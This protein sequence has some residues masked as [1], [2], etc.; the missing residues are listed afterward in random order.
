[1]ENNQQNLN[2]SKYE[3]SKQALLLALSKYEKK[4]KLKFAAKHLLRSIFTFFIIFLLFLLAERTPFQSELLRFAVNVVFYAAVILAVYGLVKIFK[5]QTHATELSSEIEKSSGRFNSALLSA[6]DFALNESSGKNSLEAV[7]KKLTVCSAAPLLTEEDSE[8]AL[9]KISIKKVSK[10]LTAILIP[11]LVWTLISPGEII[12][13]AKR[14]IIPFARISP[15]TP[16]T[17]KVLPGDITLPAGESLE[18]KAEFESFPQKPVF[19]LTKTGEN[20]PSRVEMY[21]D[22]LKDLTHAFV[23]ENVREPMKY[24]VICGKAESPEYLINAVPRPEIKT[25][26]ITLIQPAYISKEHQVLPEGETD[27]TILAGSL[28][29]AEGMSSQELKTA[30]VVFGEDSVSPCEIKDDFAFSYEFAVATDTVF[31]FTIKNNEG[32]TNKDPLSY[33]IKALED[34]KPQVEILSPGQDVPFPKSK[35]LNLKVA[36]KDD[37][38]VKSVILHYAV[39][40]RETFIPLN[41]KSDFTPKKEFEV[42]YPWLLDTLHIAPGTKIRYYVEADDAKEPQPNI[43]STPI[44]F[45]NMPSMYDVYMGEDGIQEQISNKLKDFAQER[46]L[47]NEALKEVYEKIKHE[48]T[49]D[50]ENKKALEQALEK[51]QKAAKDA[52]ELY[53]QFKKLN[54][55]MRKNPFTS[56]EA[57]EKMQTV[58]KLFQEVLDDETRQFMQELQKTLEKVNIDPAAIE[59]YQ[60]NFRMDDYIDKLDRTIELLKQVKELQQVNS[61]NEA[62]KDLAKRQEN[63]ASQTQELIDKQKAG[64]LSQEEN[65]L[66][67]DL[68]QQ[69]EKINQE[70]K[71]LEEQTDKLTKEEN[72]DSFLNQPKPFQED[73]KN[74]LDRMKNMDF[75]QKGQEITKNM[76]EKNLEK[77]LENQQEMLKFLQRL[78]EDANNIDMQMQAGA[79]QQEADF[80]PLIKKAL[81]ISRVQEEI[82]MDITSYPD[83]FMRGHMPQ[84][85]PI[86]DFLSVKQ[87]SLRKQA[88]RLDRH[89]KEM[90]TQTFSADMSLTRITEKAPELFADIIVNLENRQL[91]KAR[92]DQYI[93][94]NMYNK[95]AAELMRTQENMGEDSSGGSSDSPFQQFQNLTRRQLQLYQKNMRQQMQLGVQSQ[96]ELQQLAIEQQHIRQSLEQIMQSLRQTGSTRG[97]LNDI[98]QEMEDIETEILDPALKREVAEKQKEVYEKMLKAQKSL[99]R[100]DD[101]EESEERKAVTPESSIKQVQADTPVDDS[102]N[103]QQDLSKDF[104]SDLPEDYPPEYKNLINDYFKSL[105]IYGEKK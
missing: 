72:K 87:L 31:S 86:I 46:R 19:L 24:K 70:L 95:L 1:M 92:L 101:E 22:T 64:E 52:Q 84:I 90:V 74:I 5:S 3:A 77:S 69:Q 32:I 26:Q 40:A 8:K 11:I 6:A 98:T 91:A 18:I 58:E 81:K 33:S 65:D 88:E 4:R 44:Y 102:G 78:K 34:E 83:S 37:F 9:Q 100:R 21:R 96:E 82:L 25:M 16:M 93:I 94:I 85:E 23:L 61:I 43:A 35:M 89:V 71:Q 57:I 30:E 7:M 68:K 60:K 28:L 62:I 12:S 45:V 51:S 75:E 20:E 80:S 97:R 29:K 73:L 105:N 15:W 2:L 49:L 56:T 42:D 55:D 54:Q 48:G 13:A 66:L 76:K 27:A 41:M 36:A 104:L 50:F 14:M 67:E 17:M 53:E 79:N 39:G 99:R 63:I 47:Q 38:G 103:L 59:E 10:A